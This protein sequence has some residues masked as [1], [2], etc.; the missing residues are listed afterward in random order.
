LVVIDDENLDRLEVLASDE[1]S[2]PGFDHV[3]SA[4]RRGT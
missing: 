3:L 1:P 2:Y 4:L